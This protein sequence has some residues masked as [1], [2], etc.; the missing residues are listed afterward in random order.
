MSRLSW[1]GAAAR[2]GV[3]WLMPAGRRG[4]VEAVWAEAPEVP[5]GLRR[6]AWRAGGV[7]LIAGEAL[8]RGRI[9]SALLFA[10]AAALAAWAAWPGS[11]ASFA[12]SVDRVDVITVV[13]LL[14][15]LA[16]VARSVFGPP[17]S[18][19]VARFLR[20][21]AYGAILA[22]IPAKNV[23]EQVLD[24][25]PHGGIDLRLYR[26]ISGPGFGNHWDSEILFLVVMA[27]YAAAL[28][29]L[30]AQ[31]SRVAPATLAIGAVGGT[32]LG[33][34]WYAIGPLG[35]GGAPATNPWLPGSDI[36]PLMVLAWILLFGT[37]VAAGILADRLYTA[38]GSSVPPAGGRARQIVAA[39]L[40]TNLVGALFVTVSGT[41]TIAA[42]LK[43]A[44]LRNWLYHGHLLS[45]VAGL[46]LLL[47][48]DPGA[49]TYSHEITA[50][51]DAPPFLI[52][53]VV[54]PLIAL[55]L[56]GLG[57]L[58]LWGNAATGQGGPPSGGGGP[59]GPEAVP[60]P[61]DGAQ[62]ADD[63][64]GFLSLYERGPGTGPDRLVSDLADAA[65]AHL[66]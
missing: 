63:D 15:G 44:W 20:V 29:W 16:L 34:V 48:G 45:G 46:R 55:A 25:P 21:G 39:G 49:L 58:S 18:S 61:P 64:A 5:P 36:D 33:A 35:F 51:V 60:D 10:A 32:A 12:T 30:T 38:S 26:L 37:P 31:R 59:A 3:A 14:G 43:A 13:A 8:M 50:A 62:L 65:G 17:G 23:V 28:L 9:G 11:L 2:R 24:V 42:M 47:R 1:V 56:T 54:F 41:S 40:L 4:W 22:L 27:L 19:R 52:I 7:R 6:L 66:G 57:A 53:C